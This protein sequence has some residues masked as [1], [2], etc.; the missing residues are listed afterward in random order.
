[1]EERAERF[2]APT[3]RCS[4]SVA[5]QRTAPQDK[6]G[7]KNGFRALYLDLGD[8]SLV[9]YILDMD[10]KRSGIEYVILVGFSFSGLL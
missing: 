2:V 4:V 7:R 6:D 10:L 8:C 5:S 3:A 9:L 1:M